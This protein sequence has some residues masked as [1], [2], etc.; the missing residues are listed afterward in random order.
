[1]AAAGERLTR[2]RAWPA[3]RRAPARVHAHA[4]TGARAR[5]GEGW[6]TVDHWSLKSVERLKYM[7]I[8]VHDRLTTSH[9]KGL[10]ICI[11]NLFA[12]GVIFREEDHKVLDIVAQVLAVFV[13]CFLNFLQESEL[14]FWQSFV[15]HLVF[16][17]TLDTT[18]FA[19]GVT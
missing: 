3:G 1:L 18:N 5:A 4:G 7:V 6:Q 16:F 11:V 9:I 19:C 10:K 14:T 8:I 13:C 17:M 15:Q 2:A 12:V